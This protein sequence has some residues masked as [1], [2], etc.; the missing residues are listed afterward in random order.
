MLRVPSAQASGRIDGVIHLV[1][2]IPTPVIAAMTSRI[3][4]RPIVAAALP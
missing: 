1:Y 3:R 4:A 2:Q